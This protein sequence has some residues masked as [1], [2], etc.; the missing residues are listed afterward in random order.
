MKAWLVL[1]SFGTML[2]RRGGGGDLV[3][4]LCLAILTLAVVVAALM[5]TFAA[6]HVLRASAAPEPGILAALGSGLVGLAT[7]IRR[8][9]SR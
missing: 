8:R 3:R 7:V 2:A 5:N 1:H 6:P 9:L 4:T